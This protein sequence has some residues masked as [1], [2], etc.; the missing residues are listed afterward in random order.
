MGIHFS[1]GLGFLY[2]KE[3]DQSIAKVSYQLTETD[4][5]KYTKKKWWGELYANKEIKSVNE[6]GA[7]RIE[8]E[9]GRKGECVVWANTEAKQGRSSNYYYHFNGRSKLSRDSRSR[10]SE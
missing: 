2:V 8:F 3:V 10:K 7:H 4:P 5:T 9:D 6:V 1:N